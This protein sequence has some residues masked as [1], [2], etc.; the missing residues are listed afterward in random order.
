MDACK[1]SGLW[2]IPWWLFKHWDHQIYQNLS[3]FV[4]GNSS[5]FSTTEEYTKSTVWDWIKDSNK[6]AYTAY[7]TFPFL[8]GSP[9]RSQSTPIPLR[10]RT[11]HWW[12]AEAQELGQRV[13]L[14]SGKQRWATVSN[15]K[16]WKESSSMPCHALRILMLRVLLWTLQ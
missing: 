5:D 8:S 6:K 12:T 16:E 1:R 15:R 13:A 9:A 10:C 3:D 14:N 11:E 7:T 2:D 4:T